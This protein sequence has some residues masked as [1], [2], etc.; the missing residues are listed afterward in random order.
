MN[1]DEKRQVTDDERDFEGELRELLAE[2]A[3]TIRPSAAPYPQIRRRGALER[4]RRVAVAGAALATLAAVPAAVY[5]LGTGSAQGSTAAAPTPS[6]TATPSVSPTPSAE[7]DR[8]TAALFDGITYRQARDGLENCLD[9]EFTRDW[10][11]RPG[12][13]PPDAYAIVLAMRST[14]DSNTGGDGVFVVAQADDEERSSL[15]CR[16]E[17]GVTQGI[18]GF[19]DESDDIPDAGAVLVNP[20]SNRLFQQTVLDH[21]RWKL[22]FRW[23]V[24]GTAKPSVARVTV[25]YGDSSAEVTVDDGRFVASGVLNEQV[26]RAP[27]IKGYDAGG[28]LVYDSDDDKYWDGSLP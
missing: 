19:P 24:I 9:S 6:R 22:P 10:P 2:D 25:S 4:R 7:P 12:L 26:T 3:Y 13:A 17:D 5:G 27:H 16:L 20:N 28:E 18:T 11:G 21:G 1:D 14:G 23:A 15:I 8:A